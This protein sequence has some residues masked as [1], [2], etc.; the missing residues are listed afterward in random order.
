MVPLGVI[1]L[2]L[3]WDLPRL[4]FIGMTTM[5][6]LFGLSPTIGYYL[7]GT[8]TY[9]DDHGRE[10]VTRRLY[11]GRVAKAVPLHAGKAIYVHEKS[12]GSGEDRMTHFSIVLKTTD[13]EMRE[14]MTEHHRGTAMKYADEIAAATGLSMLTP[15]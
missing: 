10:L 9:V 14:L 7:R 8:V 3:I 4:G 15:G 1:G 2:V 12:G 6:F 5:I 13:G 11:S